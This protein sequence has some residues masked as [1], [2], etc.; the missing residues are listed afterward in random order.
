ML[1]GH[2][3]APASSSFYRRSPWEAA[4]GSGCGSGLVGAEEA[5]EEPGV[6]LVEA[7]DPE[8]GQVAWDV[9]GAA[10][11]AQHDHDGGVFGSEVAGQ[12]HPVELGKLPSR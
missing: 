2:S 9:V 4:A 3:L 11:G 6:G 7:G 10:G 1:V 12:G 8:V 5:G